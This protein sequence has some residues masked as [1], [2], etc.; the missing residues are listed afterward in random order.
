MKAT[1]KKIALV[2]LFSVFAIGFS[3]SQK[4]ALANENG[5]FG[6]INKEGTWVIEPQ[7][8]V[9]KNFSSE[10]N[11]AEATI[12]GDD[13]GFINRKGEWVIEPQFDKT[14]AFNSDIAV[15]LKDKQWFFINTKGEKILTNVNS[16]KIYDF[17]EGF[18][19]IR[20]GDF[21]GFMNT[22]GDIVI[23]PKFTKVFNFINGYSKIREGDKWG[24]IDT[25]GNYFVK[26]EYDK[27]SNVYNGNV[28][29]SKGETHGI[30]IEG[31]F[32]AISGAQKIWDFSVNKDY[33]YAKKDDLWG[34]IDN[35]GNWIVEPKYDKVRAFKNGL[36]PVAKNKKWGYI[37]LKGE[38]I[39]PLKFKDA[40]IFST[41]GLAPVKIN[42]LWGFVNSKGDLV[43]EDKYAITA[44]GFSIFQKNNQKGFIDG[45]ARV[46]DKKEWVYINTEGKVLNN[47][48]YKHLEIFK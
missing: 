5:K 15:V 36:A 29:A 24:L 22:S 44:G 30:I 12:N 16:D 31:K 41:D 18:S 9:A 13:W 35:K 19:I 26:P 38:E 8:K 43:I 20:Q 28:I 34:F 11:L 23:E 42:K 45:L 39:I 25:K 4:M 10:C 37:N 40:E 14:K 1:R 3:F 33:T 47:K 32:Q 7:F 21:V 6:Y 17:K 2:F 27:I 48:K 46:K